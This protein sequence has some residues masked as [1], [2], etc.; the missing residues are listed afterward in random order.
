MNQ[1]N[2]IIYKKFNPELKSLNKNQLLLHWKTIGIHENRIANIKIFMDKYPE[3]NLNAYKIQHKELMNKDDLTVLYYYHFNFNKNIS[4]QIFTDTNKY[5]IHSNIINQNN[6]NKETEINI[7]STK[8][9]QDLPLYI[10]HYLNNYYIFNNKCSIILFNFDNLFDETNIKIIYATF[11]EYSIYL[12]TEKEDSFLFDHSIKQVIIKNNPY[13][14]YLF[15]QN[16]PEEYILLLNEINQENYIFEKF[17]NKNFDYIIYQNN[18]FLKKE[19]LH[20]YFIGDLIHYS[21][22]CI[23]DNTIYHKFYNINTYFNN[24]KDKQNINDDLKNIFDKLFF[25]DFK[26]MI[27]YIDLTIIRNSELLYYH[28]I[29]INF[30]KCII[31]V[32]KPNNIDQKTRKILDSICF[33]DMNYLIDIIHK[34]NKKQFSLKELE[35]YLCFFID[36]YITFYQKKLNYY[37][38]IF[39]HIHFFVDEFPDNYEDQ[40][41][42]NIFLYQQINF[43]N[44][45]NVFIDIDEKIYLMKNKDLIYLDLNIKAFYYFN[46]EL[47]DIH[48]KCNF[49]NNFY[50]NNSYIERDNNN[51]IF[52]TNF[53]NKIKVKNTINKSLIELFVSPILQKNIVYENSFQLFKKVKFILY[54]E[55]DLNLL[56][57]GYLID[58]LN[59]YDNSFCPIELFIFTNNFIEKKIPKYAKIID[60]KDNNFIEYLRFNINE[61][62]LII[63]LFNYHIFHYDLSFIMFYMVL[64][65]LKTYT[66]EHSFIFTKELFNNNEIYNLLNIPLQNI[67]YQNSLNNHIHHYFFN[68][69][70]NHSSNTKFLIN[71]IIKNKTYQENNINYHLFENNSND[72]IHYYLKQKKLIINEKEFDVGINELKKYINYFT[73]KYIYIIIYFNNH[74]S[75]INENRENNC[76]VLDINKKIDYIILNYELFYQNYYFLSNNYFNECLF[77]NMLLKNNEDISIFDHQYQLEKINNLHSD[78]LEIKKILENT[79]LDTL[80]NYSR[81]IENHFLHFQY[82]Q[83]MNIYVIHLKERNDKK[84]YITNHLENHQIVFY[85]LYNAKKIKKE[86]LSQYSFI[87][88]ETFLNYLNPKYILGA[89]GCK[90][91]HYELIQS[92][93]KEK[94]Y[95]LILEDD[96]CLEEYFLFYIYYAFQTIQKENIDF[97]LL[98]L[99]AN[100]EKKEHAQ[101][102][103]PN[104]LKVN[105]PKTTTAYIINHESINKILDTIKNSTNEIDEVYS[106]SNLNKYCIYPMI[107]HQENLSSDIVNK[108]NYSNYHEKFNYTL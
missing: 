21:N 1:F 63:Y 18:Y 8:K 54:I 98:Y 74:T 89:S 67:N 35:F 33:L 94:K 108:N 66:L 2:P 29:H 14:I 47:F 97:D 44:L 77:V 57:F 93:N 39:K 61:N 91:S 41:L 60:L 5:T 26:K 20:Y 59:K 82:N 102:M 73:D 16:I 24:I 51:N 53:T 19:Y 4:N 30:Q 6:L 105:K 90:I 71:K 9:N 25:L 3:F 95:S 96:V 55:T 83:I 72:Q 37:F 92:L 23:L 65:Q 46:Q 76:I 88:T 62:D 86:E 15:L 84:K 32:N 68:K 42:K 10:N 69:L 36:Y 106:K 28:L 56:K 80:V 13:L 27:I 40:D 12:L 45:N 100:L 101:L 50:F 107:A 104:L 81:F 17:K 34:N 7:S 99:G 48:F 11:K 22:H 87:K 64:F 79:S 103:Y 43:Q 49:N 52:I 70:K 75:K 85:E 38:S 78:Y 58:K 31:I